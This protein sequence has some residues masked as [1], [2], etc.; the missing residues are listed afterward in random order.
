MRI[1]IS[2]TIFFPL[3]LLL[4]VDAKSILDDY[5][6]TPPPSH[7][8]GSGTTKKLRPLNPP[9]LTLKD[10]AP[11]KAARVKAW[12]NGYFFQSKKYC[13]NMGN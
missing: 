12:E 8:D 7:N 2:V 1:L 5:D 4:A 11:L 10:Q 9:V 13:K 3:L 6:P